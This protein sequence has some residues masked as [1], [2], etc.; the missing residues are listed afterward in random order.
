MIAFIINDI[1]TK[2]ANTLMTVN[3]PIQ[4]IISSHTTVRLISQAANIF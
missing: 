4:T 1:I 2:Y 3:F